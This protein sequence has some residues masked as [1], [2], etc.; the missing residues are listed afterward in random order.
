M[1]YVYAPDRTSERPIA[2]LAGFKGVLQVDGYGGY[3]K[4]ARSNAVALAF[5]WSHVRRKFYEL[6][7]SG[8]APIATEALQRIAALYAIEADI[9][10]RPPDERLDE[11]QARSRPLILDLEPWLVR[12]PLRSEWPGRKPSAL[13]ACWPGRRSAVRPCGY[14]SA[15]HSA[16]AHSP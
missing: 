12:V 4:L 10:G 1:A 11:R 5:C 15:A 13:P 9:R 6:A 16:R 14:A 2:H 3:G 8:S 7:A